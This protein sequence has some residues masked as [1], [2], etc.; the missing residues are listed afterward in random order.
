MEASLTPRWLNQSP[1]VIQPLK[2][3]SGFQFILRY[4]PDAE[5]RRA[6]GQLHLALDEAQW[7]VLSESASLEL[8]VPPNNGITVESYMAPYPHSPSVEKFRAM[9]RDEEKSLKAAESVVKFLRAQKWDATVGRTGRGEIPSNT[10]RISVDIGPAPYFLSPEIKEINQKIKDERKR[11]RE[12]WNKRFPAH[13][14]PPED[15]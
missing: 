2:E 15:Q 11:F 4:L 8:F 13:P 6:A 3:F 1:S 12:D 7:K 10:V 14:L 9:N 5:P